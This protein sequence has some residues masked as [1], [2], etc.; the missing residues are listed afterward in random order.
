MV[1][2]GS[3]WRMRRIV[4]GL[5]GTVAAVVLLFSYR[6]STAGPSRGPVGEAPPGIVTPLGPAAPDAGTSP[7]AGSAS[8]GGTAGPVTANG[9]VEDNGYGPVQVQVTISNGRIVEVTAVALPEDG[10]SRRI[11][12]GAVPRLR[13]EVLAA[14][15]AQ[16]DTI[17]GATLTSEAYAR[18]VQAA[19]D[20][21]HFGGGA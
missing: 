15:S 7:G 11:N 3:G 16:V 10:H 5:A 9:T 2:G 8:R 21:A 12:S 17:S 20:A 4:L 19:L 18:S 13:R 1:N 14:Q 6:T